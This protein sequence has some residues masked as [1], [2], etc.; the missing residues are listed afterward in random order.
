MYTCVTNSHVRHEGAM[1]HTWMAHVTRMNALS[2]HMCHELIYI[3]TLY[4]CD[5]F[6]C[7]HEKADSGC[8]RVI[9]HIP[10]K[11]MMCVAL[12]CNWTHCNS[13]TLCVQHTAT[14]CSCNTLQHVSFKCVTCAALHCNCN[15]LQQ[16][17]TVSATHCNTLQLQ[18]TATCL[19][20]MC[21]MCRTTL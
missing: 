13:P 6:I 11:F 9:T 8:K 4:M 10:F 17:Y 19:S 1:S 12:R 18:H 16:P 3:Y 15:T 14:L 21:D 7:G 5:K 20:Q 2:R